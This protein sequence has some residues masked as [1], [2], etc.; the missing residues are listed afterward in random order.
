M[1]Q[2]PALAGFLYISEL[3]SFPNKFSRLTPLLY[4]G[5]FYDK[6]RITVNN[7]CFKP[8]HFSKEEECGYLSSKGKDFIFTK[9]LQG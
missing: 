6:L 1:M 8:P 4:G 5:F 9:P 3:T 2:K 7:Y